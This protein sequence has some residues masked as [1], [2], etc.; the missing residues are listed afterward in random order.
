MVMG[1]ASVATEQPTSVM[2]DLALLGADYFAARLKS[3]VDNHSRF[4]P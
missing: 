4:S 3:V 1:G 2:N